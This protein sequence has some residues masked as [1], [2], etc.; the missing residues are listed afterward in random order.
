MNSDLHWLLPHL[1]QD[2][3]YKKL[4]EHLS[5]KQQQ[6]DITVLDAVRPILIAAL[7]QEINQSLLIVTHNHERARKIEEQLSLFVPDGQIRLFPYF[8][9]AP[10][11][12]EIIDIDLDN[13]IIRFLSTV[14]G[15][16]NDRPQVIIV[17]I[18]A[19]VRLL[20]APSDFSAISLSVFPGLDIS[21]ESICKQLDTFGYRYENISDT[22]GTYSRRGG[23]LDIFPPG[24]D[25]PV[26]LEFFGN[27]IETLRIY[28]PASQLTKKHIEFATVGPASL[29]L[30]PQKIS[31]VLGS[32]PIE[33]KNLAL[34]DEY[35][36]LVNGKQPEYSRFW[37]PFYNQST[38]LDYLHSKTIILLDS[39][40]L[41]DQK[42][43]FISS[44]TELRRQERISCGAIPDNYPWPFMDWDQLKQSFSTHSI[45]GLLGW[46][47]I[48]QQLCFDVSPAPS[49]VGKL[50]S[51]FQSA[52]ER[53]INGKTV[54]I[55]GYQ[56]ARIEDLLTENNINFIRTSPQNHITNTPGSV[57]LSSTQLDKGFLLGDQISIF[58]DLELFGFSKIPRQRRLPSVAKTP[59]V[60]DLSKGEYIVHVE[61]GIGIYRGIVKTKAAGSVSDYILI[62][63]SKGDRLYVPV[64]QIGRISQYIGATGKNPKLNTLGSEDWNRAKRTAENAADEIAEEFL[65][66]Y[67]A[68]H[69]A[70]GFQYSE[71]TIWQRELED[72]FP[73]TETSDQLQAIDEIK[74]DMEQPQ[75]MDRLVLGDVGYGKTEVA[76]RA[77]FKAVMDNRQVA[78]LVPTTVLAQQHYSTFSHR[79]AAFPITIDSLSR[80]RTDTEQSSIIE[81]LA[82]GSIDIIIGTHR[83]LQGDV[84]F[85]HL[86]LVIIDEEQRFGVL[87]KDYFKKLRKEIDILT[88]SATPIPRTLELSLSGIK[89]ISIIDT[90]PQ[91]RHPV[92]TVVSSFDEYLIKDA[93]ISEMERNGQIFFVH[94]RIVDI[95]RIANQLRNIVPE[96]SI[97]V[98]HGQMSERELEQVMSS[99]VDGDIDVLVC[100]TIIESGVDIPNA[101]TII[102]NDADKLGLTQLYQLRGR[103]G[104]STQSAF[105]YLLYDKNREFKGNSAQRLQTIYEAA[106]LGSGYTIALKDL[107]I[108][109]AGTLLGSKQSGQISAVGFHLY[110]ELLKEA[111]AAKQKLILPKQPQPDN[112]RRIKPPIIDAPLNAYIPESYITDESERLNYYRVLS[113]TDSLSDLDKL[114]VELTDRFGKAPPELT[115]L[116]FV[117]RLRILG[118]QAGIRRVAITADNMRLEFHNSVDPKWFEEVV[119]G[120]RVV[121]GKRSVDIRFD[122]KPLWNDQAERILWH[123]SKKRAC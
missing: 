92:K 41:I 66:L 62:E 100:T 98:A 13:E 103:V 2:L 32:S 15:Q 25:A 29:I 71:D 58:T 105:A 88:L 68:R 76:L 109:G 51:F 93:I 20:P 45:V 8:E 65:Q 36:S 43:A 27:N 64:D 3:A 80:F 97:Q 85:K 9:F 18:D 69:A 87:H 42:W 122:S 34:I 14:F 84:K 119:Q 81:R 90:P 121:S 33:W 40:E 49:Y 57:I 112:A 46:K 104:R 6:L 63:Y 99:F 115:D 108:R 48:Q 54:V 96:A 110:S 55:A 44:E 73:Y 28:D 61:H 82:S 1:R 21:P 12:H 17:S 10:F 31:T 107:E 111:I 16:N 24:S 39:P 37:Q 30:K 26:R 114:T 74:K 59:H 101:N 5:S 38:I 77:A 79:L 117:S 7:F 89:D 95:F 19:L 106:S 75:P 72:S 50:N 11:N 86:G 94:N 67:A 60:S 23:I 56:K 102:I 52:H 4:Y 53:V 120:S 113:S 116:F 118:R 70:V 47:A 91:E 22:P 83:L 123:L 35:N 78:I